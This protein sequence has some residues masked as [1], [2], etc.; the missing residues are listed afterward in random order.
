MEHS[1]LRDTRWAPAGALEDIAHDPRSRSQF[2]KLAGGTGALGALSLVVGACGAK[3]PHQRVERGP[4]VDILNYALT[5]EY[6][7]SDFYT[8]VL[9]SRAIKTRKAAD[10]AGYIGAEEQ[11]HVDSLLATLKE[12]GAKPVERPKTNFDA[13]IAGGEQKILETAATVEN[14]GAS[15]YLGQLANVTN[16]QILAATIAIHSNEARHAAALNLHLGRGFAPDGA[17]DKGLDKAS[18]LKAASPFIVG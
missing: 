14:L 2:L 12:F 17:F 9:A 3:Q 7:E 18:V 15:A 10:L 16:R 4:D 6:L 5:L 8:Q 13:V 1:G 11:Q